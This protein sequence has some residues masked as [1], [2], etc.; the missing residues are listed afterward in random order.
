M[1]RSK[2]I[3]SV[4]A[5]VSAIVS[6]GLVASATDLSAPM[7]TKAPVLLS[8]AYDWSGSYV[9]THVGYIWG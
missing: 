5:A 7:H 6:T 8:P 4:A 2:L 1:G 9:G 3:V